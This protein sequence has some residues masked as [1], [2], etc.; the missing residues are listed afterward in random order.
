MGGKRFRV[1]F[2]YQFNR[3]QKRS[4]SRKDKRQ[5]PY[6]EVVQARGDGGKN[7]R[8]A[9]LPGNPGKQGY[10]G[11]ARPAGIQEVTETGVYCKRKSARRLPVLKNGV[12]DGGRSVLCVY[13]RMI[14]RDHER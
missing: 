2:S 10:N 1:N 14:N 9:A 13:R 4:Y 12:G 3:F 7:A 8:L 5:N 11:S 6:A